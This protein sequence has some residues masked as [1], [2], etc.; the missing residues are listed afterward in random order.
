MSLVTWD[1]K[2]QINVPQ[3][4]NQHRKLIDMINNLHDAMK[5]GKGNDQLG[6]IFDGLIAYT[7]E[8]FASEERFL[9]SINYPSLNQHKELH[10]KFVQTVQDKYNEFKQG[11]AGMAKIVL[12]LLY[13]WL[14]KHIQTVD[15]E[16]GKFANSKTPASA[17]TR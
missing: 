9:Q 15:A 17:A 6:P 16:Y 7:R 4:D 5:Q 2:L 10:R 13:N 12:D 3:M 8:H 14:I 1:N 11:K